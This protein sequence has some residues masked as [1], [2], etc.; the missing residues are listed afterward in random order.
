MGLLILRPGRVLRVNEAGA[1]EAIAMVHGRK[2]TLREVEIERAH[3]DI[4][5]RMR[6][7]CH[8]CSSFLTV[9]CIISEQLATM[10]SRYFNSEGSVFLYSS[11]QDEAKALVIDDELF[12]LSD[13]PRLIDIDYYSPGSSKETSSGKELI[14]NANPNI[15]FQMRVGR[16]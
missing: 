16:K 14:R 4:H 1:N 3:G 5:I 9:S 12:R 2:F 8:H 15:L 10:G 7:N 13:L 6:M 11:I